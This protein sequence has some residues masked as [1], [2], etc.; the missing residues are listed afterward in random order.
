[1]ETG[2]LSIGPFGPICVWQSPRPLKGLRTKI[3]YSDVRQEGYVRVSQP[4][5][6]TIVDYT[7]LFG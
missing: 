4:E 6:R 5:F 3:Q 1:M 2:G 7:V